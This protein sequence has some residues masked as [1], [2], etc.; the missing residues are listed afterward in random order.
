MARAA[1]LD[2]IDEAQQLITGWIAGWADESEFNWA[3]ADRVSDSLMG[4]VSL[5]NVDLHDGTAGVAYWMVPAWRGRG[6]CSEAVITLCQW[7]FNKAGF[8]RL[9]LE[10]SMA[11][12]ASC[13]VAAKAGFQ[14]EGIRR[15]AALHADG[16]HDMHAHALLAHQPPAAERSDKAHRHTHPA[17]TVSDPCGGEVIVRAAD[18]DELG[19]VDV[20]A[21]AI[22]DDPQKIRATVERYRDDPAVRLLVAT[23]CG[24]PV[25]VV[26]YIGREIRD[27]TV[28][29]RDNPVRAADRTRTPPPGRG[30]PGWR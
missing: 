14:E 20:V 26:G 30:T 15:E 25:G 29:H 19:V 17:T 10:H 13:R 11:N 22:G 24:I 3:L 27:H 1:R 18:I 8:H 2:S 6:F 12:V 21:L 7:A 23:D 28:A 5:K 16:W 4:R 9:G